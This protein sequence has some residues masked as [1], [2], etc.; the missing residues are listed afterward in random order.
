MC[1]IRPPNV[2]VA[3]IFEKSRYMYIRNALLIRL[4]KILRQP[5]TGFALLGAHQVGAVP[6]FPSTLCSTW[7]QIGLFLEKYN[8]LQ[9]NLVATECAA[10]GRLMFQ[11]LRYSKN[12]DTCIDVMHHSYGCCRRVFSNLAATQVVAVHSKAWKLA[13]GLF[14]ELG[15]LIANV[16]TPIEVTSSVRYGGA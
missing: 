2:S 5:T 16:S 3:T 1:C 4:L 8:N 12:R 10:S 7:T 13:V 15:N 9:I 14:A 6:E 11:L